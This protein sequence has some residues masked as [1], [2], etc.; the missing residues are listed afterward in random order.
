[1]S[2]IVAQASHE[3]NMPRMDSSVLLGKRKRSRGSWL[4]VIQDGK[5]R[6]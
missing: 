3:L 2:A 6:S 5:K 4:Q 1:M